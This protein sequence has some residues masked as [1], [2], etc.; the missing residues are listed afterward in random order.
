MGL[1]DRIAH[2]G[3]GPA[4][5][6]GQSRR[7]RHLIQVPPQERRER[8]RE[9]EGAALQVRVEGIAEAA[10]IVDGPGEE[11]QGKRRGE[12]PGCDRDFE[13]LC[14]LPHGDDGRLVAMCRVGRTVCD[15]V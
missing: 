2:E 1:I 14:F 9:I 5:G 15:G 13:R 8:E 11:R 4:H 3:L 12:A 6:D 10:N 7:R